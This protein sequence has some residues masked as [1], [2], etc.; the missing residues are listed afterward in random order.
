LR[1]T[2]IAGLA[3]ALWAHPGVAFAE[4]ATG[5]LDAAHVTATRRVAVEFHT[6]TPTTIAATLHWV[7]AGANLDLF[8]ARRRPEGSWRRVAAAASTAAHPEQLQRTHARPGTYRLMVRATSGSSTY[9]LVFDAGALKPPPPSPT[10]PFLTLL[11]SRTEVTAAPSCVPEVG[12]MSLMTQV[13]PALQ[14]RGLR[15]TGSVE[16]GV[17]RDRQ[18]SC[19][20]YRHTLAASWSDLAT[21]RD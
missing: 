10:G 15:P 21:L 7:N 16:T 3:L 17:T 1:R 14:R 13:A 8:L 18:R 4:T 6:A 19:I 2:L 12:A 11:F 5:R 9:R 20:H